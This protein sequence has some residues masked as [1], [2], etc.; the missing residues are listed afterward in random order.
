MYGKLMLMLV[1]I[2]LLASCSQTRYV[3]EEGIAPQKNKLILYQKESVPVSFFPD[4]IRVLSIGDSLTEGVGDSQ[5]AGGYLPYLEKR[6]QKEPT[7]TSVEM[8]NLGVRGNR[9]DQLL[10]RL[11][12]EETKQ[13]V[14]EADAVVITI[15]GND[16]MK[17][18]RNHF[19]NLE[20]KQFETAREEYEL[21]LKQILD[22]IRMNNEEAQIYLVGVYNP[23]SQWFNSLGELELIM[24]EWNESSKAIVN[25]YSRAKF[26][27]ID[28]I[29]TNG[30]A[31]LL[32]TEDYF[33]PNDDGYHLIAERIYTNMDIKTLGDTRLTVRDK[34]DE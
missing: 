25:G 14:A 6:L 10:S 21:R 12:K 2:V 11:E 7:V 24:D 30:G 13:E 1:C 9:S 22:T 16:I 5:D 18:V 29:F 26:I 19:I 15:G 34:G 33:H 31:E 20:M 32:Y 27:D 28:D 23:F 8:V 17:V 4:P 3:S